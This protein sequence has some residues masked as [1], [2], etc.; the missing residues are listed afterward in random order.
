MNKHLGALP[1]ASLTIIKKWAHMVNT[2]V[3]V[4]LYT[5]VGLTAHGHTEQIIIIK[6][7]S[8][9]SCLKHTYSISLEGP[10]CE[11][12]FSHST[13]WKINIWQ[14]LQ[15]PLHSSRINIS[16]TASHTGFNNLSPLCEKVPRNSH[17]LSLLHIINNGSGI[18]RD[19]SA[20]FTAKSPKL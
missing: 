6:A 12:F 16:L 8:C 13:Y 19:W 14:S 4:S 9:L 5:Q 3:S 15:E 7:Y 20:W 10:V 18:Q 11:V 17:S 1:L 2:P